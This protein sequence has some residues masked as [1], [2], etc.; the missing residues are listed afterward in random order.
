MTNIDG[1]INAAPH[2][3][4][5]L[6]KLGDHVH[7]INVDNGWFEENRSMGDE[8]ALL[9]SEV[10]E[11]FECYR[12]GQMGETVKYTSADGFSIVKRGDVND[13]SFRRSGLIGKPLGF[14]SE[15]ADILIRLVDTARRYDV[16]L[17]EATAWKLEYNATRGYKHGGKAV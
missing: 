3:S 7:A 11:A 12:E 6:E 2:R 8:M 17:A 5:Y 1:T 9:H 10:S 15:L 14:A 16:D 13:N 4:S